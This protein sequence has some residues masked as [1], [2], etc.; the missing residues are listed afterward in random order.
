MS[1]ASN[2][3]GN[4]RLPGIYH[5]ALRALR[6]DGWIIMFGLKAD[7]KGAFGTAPNLNAFTNNIPKYL[8]SRAKP[9]DLVC[10][11]TR[12]NGATDPPLLCFTI[13][14]RDSFPMDI[15]IV[16]SAPSSCRTSPATSKDDAQPK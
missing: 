12:R 3:Q 7:S 1:E 8:P 6:N 15:Q 5:V 2:C 14:L 16:R 10:T 9:R 11:L 4:R 13:D